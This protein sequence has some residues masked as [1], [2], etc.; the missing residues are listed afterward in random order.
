MGGAGISEGGSSAPG[1]PGNNKGHI[2]WKGVS[3]K[4]VLEVYLHKNEKGSII[5][6]REREREGTPSSLLA[7]PGSCP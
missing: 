4:L 1:V 6:I 5:H 3:G 7:L 2:L